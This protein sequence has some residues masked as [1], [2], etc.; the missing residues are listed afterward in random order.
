MFAREIHKE[1]SQKLT[2]SRIYP[3]GS[4]KIIKASGDYLLK[5][6]DVVELHTK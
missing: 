6:G 2:F 3:K 5:E 4:D 1:L